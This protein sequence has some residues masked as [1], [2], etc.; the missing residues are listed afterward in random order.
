[1]TRRHCQH[2]ECLENN[3]RTVD[4]KMS[5]WSDVY[6]FPKITSKVLHST[7]YNECKRNLIFW[8]ICSFFS[9]QYSLCFRNENQKKRT[10]SNDYYIYIYCVYV[11]V[12]HTIIVTA[13][14][15]VNFYSQSV[16]NAEELSLVASRIVIAGKRV[17][18]TPSCWPM[19]YGMTFS[20]SR[21][22]SKKTSIRKPL[23]TYPNPYEKRLIS[24]DRSITMRTWW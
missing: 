7:K 3:G 14:E 5:D 20:S 9:S 23:K 6:N 16:D 8:N 4:R 13:R 11:I 22:L 24:V 12:F 1:M 2:A 21:F 15:I 19:V 17:Y 10:K 18:K